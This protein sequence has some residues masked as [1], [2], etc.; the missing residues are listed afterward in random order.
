MSRSIVFVSSRFGGGGAE[1]HLLRLVNGLTYKGYQI[2]LLLTQGNGE[3]EK[4]LSENVNITYLSRDSSSYLWSLLR[5]II[6]LAGYV[7]KRDCSTIIPI[8]DGP[9]LASI[10]ARILS[11][12]KPK[13]IGWVQNNPLHM[14]ASIRTAPYFLGVKVLFRQLDHL[15]SL[16]KGVAQEYIKLVPVLANSY[17]VIPNI[18]FPEK[19]IGSYVD[20]PTIPI[21]DQNKINLIACGRLEPQKNYFMMLDAFKLA[22]E[23]NRKIHLTIIGKGSLKL[24]IEKYSA[25]LGLSNNVTFIGF[26]NDPE[27]LIQ[28]ASIFLLSS[29]FE[30]FG[31]VIVEAMASGVPVI[32]TDCSYGPSEII[33]DGIDGMLVPVKSPQKMAEKIIEL[34]EDKGKLNSLST[35]GKVKANNYTSEVISSKFLELL[36]NTN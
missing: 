5:S 36:K 22:I 3:Y 7:N 17:N 12:K 20:D 23:T 34:L 30:G 6:S 26:I 24:H 4:N 29:D 32:S 18:G 28:Q 2:E 35:A 11:R 25:Q 31:N 13:I 8:Q 33:D 1:K 27:R 14:K 21:L 9:I 10:L 15:I 16:S 19:I